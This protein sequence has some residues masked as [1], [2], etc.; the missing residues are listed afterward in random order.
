MWSMIRYPGSKAK[1]AEYITSRFPESMQFALWSDKAGWE[2]REPFFGAGAVGFSVMDVLAPRCPIWIN[3]LD[4]GMCALWRSVKEH[5]RDLARLISNFAPSTDLFYKFKELDGDPLPNFL[6]QGF[7]KLALHRMSY[8]G[9]GVMSGGPLGG[10]N[11]SSE[12]NVNCRWNPERI[13]ENLS[14]LNELLNRFKNV[15]ITNLDFG[16]VIKDAPA[17]C[18][19]YADPPYYEKG[20]ELYKHSMSEADHARLAGLLRETKATWVLS[21]D[22]HPAIRELYSWATFEQIEL[23]YTTAFSRGSR[24]KNQEVI[25]T[26]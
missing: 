23:K 4:S 19:I 7:R 10:R 12:Y 17:E 11:Q 13:I 14:S 9:L 15:Q 3:D 21:Y 8:S 26:P 1:L 20:P 2:Y 5:P 22:E 24:P 6:W 18:F 25:I 16:E